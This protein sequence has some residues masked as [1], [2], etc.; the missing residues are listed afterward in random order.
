M[1]QFIAKEILDELSYTSTMGQ[2][3]KQISLSKTPIENILIDIAKYRASYMDILVQ[4]NLIGS[5]FKSDDSIIRK[6]QKTLRT[7]GGFKQ[8][9]NDVLGFRLHF[10]Q[11]PENYPEY[12]R[13][14]DLRNGKQIDDGY[15]AIHLY[16]QRDNRAYPIE[17]QLWCA[18]DYQFNVWS[19]RW[20]YKYENAE[21]GKRLYELYQMENIKTEKEFL[22]RFEEK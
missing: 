10:D 1:D 21:I 15:R 12:Y 17:V 6:Y 3:L 19:H 2:S 11:Y 8:C 22:K 5:R 13:V 4:E 20:I 9:F 14:V 18:K 16:Y 7:G